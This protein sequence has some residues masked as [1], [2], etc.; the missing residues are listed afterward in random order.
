[1]CDISKKNTRLG[2]SAIRSQSRESRYPERGRLVKVVFLD[3][4]KVNG[5]RRNK[6]Y[7]FNALGS[8]TPSIPLKSTKEVK[9]KRNQE[10]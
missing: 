5:M 9:G 3:T 6:G 1:M 8:E 7:K 10:M 4:N 2:V